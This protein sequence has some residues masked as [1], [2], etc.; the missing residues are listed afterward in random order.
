MYVLQIIIGALGV[1][2]ITP[3]KYDF[4]L[5]LE[6]YLYIN[7]ETEGFFNLKLS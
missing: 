4:S 3:P 2:S 1:F 5:T 6:I 7:Q